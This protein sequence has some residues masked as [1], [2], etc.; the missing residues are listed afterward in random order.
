MIRPAG[1]TERGRPH[2]GVGDLLA[3][4]VD[5]ADGGGVQERLLG[6]RHGVASGRAA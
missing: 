2:A 5:V 1:P 6:Q 4:G 3:V